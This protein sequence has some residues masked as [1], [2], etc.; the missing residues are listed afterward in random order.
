LQKLHEAPLAELQRQG[1]EVGLENVERMRRGDLVFG[2]AKKTGDKEQLIFGRGVLEVHGEGFGFL[3]SPAANFLP[4]PDD[5]YVSPS[6]VRK[7]A[8]RTGDT[9]DGQIRAPKDGE[10]Y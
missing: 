7:F 4:G 9:V 1:R 8:L 3:R 2:I 10:R 6:Q 5:I